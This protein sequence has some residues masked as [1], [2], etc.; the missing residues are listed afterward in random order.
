MDL[1]TMLIASFV[2]CTKR[3]TE[4]ITSVFGAI[5]VFHG[6]LE[7]ILTQTVLVEKKHH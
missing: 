4:R 3:Y 7:Y 5:T 6:T 2:L 1:C